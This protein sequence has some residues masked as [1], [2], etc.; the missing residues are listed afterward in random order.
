V[1]CKESSKVLEG[2]SRLWAQILYKVE[3]FKLVVY[4]DL[5]F[6][7]VK[8]NGVFTLGYLMSLGLITI[9]WRSHKQSVLADSTTEAK[10]VAA[11]EAKK[12]IVWLR[13]ILEDLQEK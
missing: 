4:I 9:S 11:V 6:D 5:D 3:D 2:N 10:Y 1:C 12:E 7:V 13:K 8:E